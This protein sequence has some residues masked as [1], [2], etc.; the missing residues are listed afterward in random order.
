MEVG[1]LEEKIYDEFVNSD[2]EYH[3][4]DKEK[5]YKTFYK[6]ISEL[7]YSNNIEDFT[8]KEILEMLKE[9]IESL[10]DNL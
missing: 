1:S 6:E 9:L 3:E 10:E 2:W 4:E 5:Y 7:V 8:K